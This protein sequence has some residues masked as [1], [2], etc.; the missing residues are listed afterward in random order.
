MRIILTREEH[1]QLL[2]FLA[3]MGV[4]A[5]VCVLITL[6]AAVT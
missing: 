2:D 3:G 4:C 5:I 6:V 1:E